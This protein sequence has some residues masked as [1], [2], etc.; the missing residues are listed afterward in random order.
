TQAYAGLLTIKEV[1]VYENTTGTDRPWRPTALP[2]DMRPTASIQNVKTL[3]ESKSALD[4]APDTG[5]STIEEKTLRTESLPRNPF[6]R[7]V[8]LANSGAADTYRKHI[9]MTDDIPEWT[10]TTLAWETLQILRNVGPL[11]EKVMQQYLEVGN[12]ARKA[13]TTP[14]SRFVVVWVLLHQAVCGDVQKVCKH[15]CYTKEGLVKRVLYLFDYDLSEALQEVPQEST[16][17]RPCTSGTTTPSSPPKPSCIS[18]EMPGIVTPTVAQTESYWYKRLD[19]RLSGIHGC[20]KDLSDNLVEAMA[21]VENILV[22]IAEQSRVS[23]EAVKDDV[24]LD[25]GPQ[26]ESTG[27]QS[28][29]ERNIPEPYLPSLEDQAKVL[30]EERGRRSSAKIKAKAAPNKGRKR[31]RGSKTDE[32]VLAC[33]RR[34]VVLA[35]VSKGT[36]VCTGK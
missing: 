3:Q 11:V 13:P 8:A 17:K 9:N 6:V 31:G 5:V 32:V 15:F 35:K 30:Q 23:G 21:R 28:D 12:R 4:Y 10:F 14:G 34:R 33:E 7:L 36:P 22:T 18:R 16:Q 25:A 24:D 26:A 29:E 27:S 20:V 2:T 19:E 1:K